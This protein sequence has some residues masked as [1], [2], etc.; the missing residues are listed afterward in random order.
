MLFAAIFSFVYAFHLYFF[1]IIGKQL[2]FRGDFKKKKHSVY[3]LSIK[4]LLRFRLFV[5][6][7]P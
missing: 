5:V 3:T 6:T 1:H 7:L 4:I 2:V